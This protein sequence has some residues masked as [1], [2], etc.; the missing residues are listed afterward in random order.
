MKIV[1]TI[2]TVVVVLALLIWAGITLSNNKKKSEEETRIVAQVNDRVAVNVAQV[3]TET[4]S[5]DYVANGNFKTYQEMMFESEIS[6]KITRE[7]VD[8]GSYVSIRQTLAIIRADTQSI[9]LTAA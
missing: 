4:L 2:L 3:K 1:R 6:G 7:L 5:S 8:E 9:E